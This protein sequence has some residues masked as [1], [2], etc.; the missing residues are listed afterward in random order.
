LDV[1]YHPIFARAFARTAGGARM[2]ALEFDLCA[3]TAF[4]AGISSYREKQRQ[5]EQGGD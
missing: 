4:N 3:L 1:I 2:I 5:A